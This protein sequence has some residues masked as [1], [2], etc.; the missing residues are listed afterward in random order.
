MADH[1]CSAK[2]DVLAQVLRHQVT[3]VLAFCVL[4]VVF[5]LV[6]TLGDLL[7]IRVLRKASSMPATEKKLF[8]S[9]FL[10][11]FCGNVFVTIMSGVI[12]AVMLK[13]TSTKDYNFVPFCPTILTVL[14]Y[15]SSLIAIASFLNITAITVDRLFV[16]SLNLRY[17]D[18]A[19]SKRVFIALVLLWLTSAVTAFL[20]IFLSKSN[21]IIVVV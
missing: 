20:Y 10:R 4:N 8:L 12:L 15:L 17:Q 3:P 13:M 1:F 5:S 9:C 18:L 11:P 19:T 21:M 2:L 14:L 6:E 16:V 7:V